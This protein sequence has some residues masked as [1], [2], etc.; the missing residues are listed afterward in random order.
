MR[1]PPEV[2]LTIDQARPGDPTNQQE[3]G[4]ILPKTRFITAFEGVFFVRSL[5]SLISSQVIA[6]FPREL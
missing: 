2:L 4:R 3:P 6:F 1:T 5:S